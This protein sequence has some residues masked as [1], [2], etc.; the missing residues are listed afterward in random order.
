MTDLAL[1][2]GTDGGGHLPRLIEGYRDIRDLAHLAA[3]MQEIGFSDENI[4]TY[5]GGNLCRVLRGCIG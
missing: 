3:A 4:K 2:L 1:G 5:M